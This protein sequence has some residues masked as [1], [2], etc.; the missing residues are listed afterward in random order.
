MSDISFHYVAGAFG[1]V[2]CGASAV[3]SPGLAFVAGKGVR[4]GANGAQGAICEHLFYCDET[5]WRCK[6]L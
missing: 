6:D 2:D 5:V 1:G 4:V 3:R